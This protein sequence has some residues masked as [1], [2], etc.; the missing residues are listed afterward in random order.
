M[1]ITGLRFKIKD[2]WA[3][4][5]SEKFKKVEFQ[6]LDIHP[7]KD[8]SRGLLA[9]TG[10]EDPKTLR[11]FLSS[12]EGITRTEILL[13]E[14][15][16]K[17]ISFYFKHGPLG[18]IILKTGVH[19]RHPLELKDGVISVNLIGT[20]KNIKQFFEKAERLKEVSME[21]VRKSELKRLRKPRITKKQEQ[22]LKTAIKLGYYDIPRGITTAGLAGKMSLAPSTLSEH[23]RKAENR[24]IKDY[25]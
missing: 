4:E 15:D 2:F 11:N 9:I 20:S 12:R 13:D 8:H 16:K 1:I 22:I 25:F 6:V 10:Q 18:E 5:L 14:A 3:C 24:I 7:S 23:L 19:I 21:I 17:L